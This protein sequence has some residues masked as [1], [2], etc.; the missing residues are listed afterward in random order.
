[1]SRYETFLYAEPYRGALSGIRRLA[2]KYEVYFL[3]DP[4]YFANHHEA[5]PD[6]TANII[7]AKLWWLERYNLDPGRVIFSS[8][9]AFCVGNLLVDDWPSCFGLWRYHSELALGRGT[10]QAF[11]I[12]RPWNQN[13]T[14]GP[15]GTA[16]SLLEIARQLVP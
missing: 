10:A 14:V 3:T 6:I 2:D 1:M 5:N 8:R 7:K 12:R 13:E 16:G 15:H 11:M 9:K 4:F